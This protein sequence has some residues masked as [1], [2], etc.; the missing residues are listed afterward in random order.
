M[1]KVQKRIFE[2]AKQFSVLY[3]TLL[4]GTTL[5]SQILVLKSCEH[6]HLSF[7]IFNDE[8][9]ELLVANYTG[10]YVPQ[11][12]F[13]GPLRIECNMKTTNDSKSQT[14]VRKWIYKGP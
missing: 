13:D 5:K 10:E 12:G 4:K 7:S 8:T 1:V 6:P 14:T 11:S 3:H 9:N 2:S